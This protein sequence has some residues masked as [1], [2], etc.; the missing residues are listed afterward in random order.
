MNNAAVNDKSLWEHIFSFLLDIYLGVK[1]LGHS[2]TAKGFQSGCTPLPTDEGSSY[3]TSLPR[4]DMVH[5]FHFCDFKNQDC[6]EEY[7][8]PQ[9]CRSYHSNGRKGRGTKEALDEGDRVM[10]DSGSVVS[11]S[12]RSLGP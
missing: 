11:D 4:V 10:S 12:L 7:Q 8:Q 3:S 2:E 5:L 6:Q 9:I 1:F